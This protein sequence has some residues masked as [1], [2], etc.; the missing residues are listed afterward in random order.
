MGIRTFDKDSRR[1]G[2]I[3]FDNNEVLIIVII[4]LLAVFVI[5]AIVLIYFLWRRHKSKLA[6]KELFIKNLFSKFDVLFSPLFLVN[7]GTIAVGSR[8]RRRRKGE[9]GGG[10]A[11]SRF[12]I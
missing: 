6:L 12:V 5:L 3:T 10:A 8:K 2:G 11:R 7:Q 9:E 4:V 1:V